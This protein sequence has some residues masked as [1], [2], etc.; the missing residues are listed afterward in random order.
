MK[1]FSGIKIFLVCLLGIT[2]TFLQC[3]P[4][5]AYEGTMTLDVKNS[6]GQTLTGVAVAHDWTNG[7]LEKETFA[8]LR[9]GESQ[10]FY[11]E[12]GSGGHDQWTVSFIEEDGSC[13]YRVG[14]QC[15]VLS[16]DLSSG[17]PVTI[18]LFG[19]SSGFSV[20]MPSSDSCKEN[21]VNSCS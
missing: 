16:S 9:N 3:S 12:V 7:G 21:Y 1:R 17:G 19:G 6:S 2:L 11:I 18:S 5:F 4:A 14:K 8:N 10:S 20:N 13:F 15:D